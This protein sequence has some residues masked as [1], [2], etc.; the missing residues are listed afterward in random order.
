MNLPLGKDERSNAKAKKLG[1]SQ[2]HR[3][4]EATRGTD[5]CTSEPNKVAGTKLR[6][7]MNSASITFPVLAPLIALGISPVIKA[8]ITDAMQTPTC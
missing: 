8:Q 6:V 1:K 2:T 4:D 3:P 5:P 7:K